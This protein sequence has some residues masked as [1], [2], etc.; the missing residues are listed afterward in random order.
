[1]KLQKYL[2]FTRVGLREGLQY[3]ADTLA[4]I[5]STLISL[6][7]FYFVWKAIAASGELA[8]PFSTIIAY[9]ALARVIDNATSANLESWIGD[10]IRRGT[11]VN[12]LK[13][14]V[15]LRGQLYFYE[16]GRSMFK[17]VVRGIP[18]LIAGIIFLNVGVPGPRN[19]FLFCVSIFLTLNLAIA[20]SYVTSMLVFWT[21]I[22]WSLRMMRTMLAGL[23]S[24]AMI[25]LYLVPEGLRQFF[26]YT[27][28]PSMVDGPISIYQGT[29]DSVVNVLGIQLAWIIGLFLL[30]EVLWRK[31][32]KILTVQ[33][34]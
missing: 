14:P 9:V 16:I 31:A 21:K 18:S 34:G 27:P 12:E 17:L 3:R 11:I 10:R 19:A 4:G 7:L 15:S 28:F 23:L 6:V 30:A 22:G 2:S 13:K 1:M 29:A 33:G 8:V 20:L 5:G 26:Y 24:G 25:P 32:K